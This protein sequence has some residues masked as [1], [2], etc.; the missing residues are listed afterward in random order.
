ML[1][2]V[3][4][5]RASQTHRCLSSSRNTLASAHQLLRRV[6]RKPT[7]KPQPKTQYNCDVLSTAEELLNNVDQS[8]LL[9]DALQ[10]AVEALVA[11]NDELRARN[12][13]LQQFCHATAH[14]TVPPG[15]MLSLND[16]VRQTTL[17][18]ALV[19]DGH[20]QAGSDDQLRH[21]LEWAI[22]GLR[23]LA[24]MAKAPRAGNKSTREAIQHHAGM[25]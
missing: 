20:L 10:D 4:E 22:D 25:R 17:G 19:L 11:E 2:E 9:N 7:M 14:G 16:E 5:E 13:A 1:S 23:R 6:R 12:D 8:W 21:D 18:I 24:N 15:S 3:G